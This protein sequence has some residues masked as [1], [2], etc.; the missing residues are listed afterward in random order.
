VERHA[1]ALKRKRQSPKRHARNRAVLSGMKNLQKKLNTALA[2]KK[3]DEAQLLLKKS[4]SAFDRAAS[5]GV[6]HHNTAARKVS[7]LTLKVDKTLSSQK[8]S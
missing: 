8:T 3:T 6:I 4:V 1:S 2:T 7:R 5:K